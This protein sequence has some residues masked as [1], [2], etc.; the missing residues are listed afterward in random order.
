MENDSNLAKMFPA[1]ATHWR[2]IEIVSVW[3][4]ILLSLGIEPRTIYELSCER[5]PEDE[6]DIMHY[7]RQEEEFR[8]RGAVFRNALAAMSLSLVKVNDPKY[9]DHVRL[10]DFVVW[11]NGKGWSMPEW[12]SES[13]DSS[14]LKVVPKERVLHEVSQH[15]S[16]A[17][18]PIQVVDDVKYLTMKELIVFTG[19]GRQTIYDAIKKGNFPAQIYP[20]GSRAARW[21]KSAI[22]AHMQQVVKKVDFS[23]L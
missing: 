17:S 8:S 21:E 6:T 11:A 16:D 10:T 22:V 5:D 20:T 18:A 2:G 4:A 12:L 15:A 3:Q 19:L 14:E 13:A 9:S 1:D 7:G 23:L